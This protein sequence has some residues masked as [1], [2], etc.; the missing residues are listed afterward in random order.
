M[1]NNMNLHL[2][3]LTVAGYQNGKDIHCTCA[4]IKI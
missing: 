4:C 2:L 1:K 3:T